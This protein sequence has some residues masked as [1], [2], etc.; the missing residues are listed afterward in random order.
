MRPQERMRGGGSSGR[1]H[2][3]PI[4]NPDWFVRRPFG[5]VA[6]WRHDTIREQTSMTFSVRR[7]QETGADAAIRN[8]F[9]ETAA[10]L[11]AICEGGYLSQVTATIDLLAEA[12]QRGNKLLIY[13]N[14]AS[15]SDA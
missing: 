6:N 7:E 5:L 8:I 11:T 14:G 2:Q 4:S 3:L 12:F 10:N 15:A 9:T 13:G 1:E